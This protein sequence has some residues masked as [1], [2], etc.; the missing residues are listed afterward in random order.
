[1]SDG[2]GPA[3]GQPDSLEFIVIEKAF[4]KLIVGLDLDEILKLVR[5]VRRPPEPGMNDNDIL[6]LRSPKNAVK[7]LRIV[8][9]CSRLMATCEAQ[10]E[11]QKP[12]RLDGAQPCPDS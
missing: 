3:V 7:I 2:V 1:M 10:Q 11:P 4:R 5:P 6:R 12:G 8:L 9:P